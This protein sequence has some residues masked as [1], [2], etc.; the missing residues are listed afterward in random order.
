MQ[1]GSLFGVFANKQLSLC[2]LPAWR[3][4]RQR[5]LPTLSSQLCELY[6][7]KRNYLHGVHSR[8]HSSYCPKQYEMCPLWAWLHQ[9]RLHKT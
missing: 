3:N 5:P 7:W 6:H 9:M 8:I 4:P 1:S 2:A